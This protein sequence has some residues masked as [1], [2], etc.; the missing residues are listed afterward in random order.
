MWINRFKITLKQDDLAIRLKKA[1]T[2]SQRY[3]VKP[4]AKGTKTPKE[5]V[6]KSTISLFNKKN[7]IFCKK[8]G[9]W[10]P[11]TYPKAIGQTVNDPSQSTLPIKYMPKLKE[12]V[13]NNKACP[14]GLEKGLVRS[15]SHLR[16]EA[17]SISLSLAKGH[18]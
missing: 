17:I 8:K 18:F 6:S 4:V 2:A 7:Y 9:T 12:D 5:L 16:K 3:E 11:S 13:N 1:K 15:P 10:Q 14:F